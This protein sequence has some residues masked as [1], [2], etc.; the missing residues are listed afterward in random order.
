MTTA[1][2]VDDV[3]VLGSRST[4]ASTSDVVIV[5]GRVWVRAE[6]DGGRDR[7][8][9]VRG[10]VTDLAGNAATDV[11]IVRGARGARP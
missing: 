10:T 11:R 9:T 8:Y 5:G 1:P 2:G 7:V 4:S 3:A 6:R